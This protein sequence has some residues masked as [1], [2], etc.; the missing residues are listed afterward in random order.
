MG[1]IFTELEDTYVQNAAAFNVFMY[2][3]NNYKVRDFHE[4]F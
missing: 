1:T 2:L 4:I 3:M